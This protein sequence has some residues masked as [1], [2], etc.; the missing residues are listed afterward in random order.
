[1]FPIG[2]MSWMNQS[3]EYRPDLGGVV[4]S[5]VAPYQKVADYF[6][7]KDFKDK[8][9]FLCESAPD[10]WEVCQEAFE[11]EGGL[12][13]PSALQAET[14]AGGDARYEPPAAVLQYRL[15]L[16]AGASRDYRFIFGPAFDDAEI[17]AMRDK[18]LSADAFAAAKHAYAQ[19]VEGGY[20]CLSI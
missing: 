6:K 16:G 14:L 19:Y 1:Y 15:A 10:A 2:Y 12:H 4:A 17:R 13:A 8:T 5:C 18:Y 7:Q 3:G 9:Y 20:G 11:G